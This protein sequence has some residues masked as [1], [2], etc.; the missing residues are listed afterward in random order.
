MGLMCYL[1]G[2]RTEVI[3]EIVEE[4]H[5][6]INWSKGLIYY[7][8][9]VKRTLKHRCIRCGKIS[10]TAS[11]YDGEVSKDMPPRPIPDSWMCD[12]NGSYRGRRRPPTRYFCK[13]HKF[14]ILNIN[15]EPRN[16][17]CEKCLHGIT[18]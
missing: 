2:C 17:R 1:F 3:E 12:S 5:P 18:K 16:Y 4:R 15:D 6:E 8:D 13:E 7:Y 11:M 9:G 10:A 14:P